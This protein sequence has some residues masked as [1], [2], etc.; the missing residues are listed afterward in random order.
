MT[1]RQYG[2]TYALLSITMLA[3]GSATYITP[4]PW[5]LFLLPPIAGA[6]VALYS[7]VMAGWRPPVV[8][9][10]NVRAVMADGREVPLELMYAGWRDGCHQWQTTVRLPETP[11]RVECAALP[12]GAQIGVLCMTTREPEAG[13]LLW[14]AGQPVR[15]DA[16]HVA[17]DQ[18]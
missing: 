4:W 2:V 8:P 1:R 5:S 12:A 10:E 7:L 9:P 6:C 18:P 13:P 16:P 14:V 3:I 17:P 11:V 15:P